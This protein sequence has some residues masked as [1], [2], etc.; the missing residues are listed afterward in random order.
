ME[1]GIRQ[2]NFSYLYWLFLASKESADMANSNVDEHDI[3]QN[4]LQ[5]K[6]DDFTSDYLFN[7]LDI[8]KFLQKQTKQDYI[9]HVY[10]TNKRN[11]GEKILKKNN[12]HGKQNILLYT[13]DRNKT[14]V[15][16]TNTLCVIQ[17]N[18]NKHIINVVML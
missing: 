16:T 17:E 4:Y 9:I 2:N 18:K 7:N 13:I 1:N 6:K 10:K 3:E 15:S 5:F 8:S 11:D 14:L 12:Y